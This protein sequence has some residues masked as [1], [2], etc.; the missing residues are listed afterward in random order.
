MKNKAD[1]FVIVGPTASGKTGL[2]IELA[3]RVA[4]EVISADSRQVYRGLDIGTEKVTEEEMQ[5]VPHHCIDIASPRR[6]FSVA[7]WKRHAE[8]ALKG[9][10][11]RGHV[12]IVAGGSG[13]F[14]DTL[15]YDLHFPKVAPNASLRRRLHH[16]DTTSLLEILRSLDPK[17][18]EHIEPE[19]PR[20]L[21]R[22]IE[23]ATALGSVPPLEYG[24][25][26]YDARWIGL[27]PGMDVLERRI[28]TRLD[29][30]L[31]RGLIEETARLSTELGLSRS[32]ID[33]L[34]LEYRLVAAHL[35]GELSEAEL[36]E[37]M[38]IE[39]RRY[40]KRQMTWFR[41]HEQIEWHKTAC[42]VLSSIGV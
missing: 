19:N 38:R 11:S 24:E 23:I 1:I 40:A 26:R 34:G 30:A 9:I 16:K 3:K 21:V 35:R 25:S 14:V 18:A 28:A 29:Q 2:S 4:G 5:G 10:V 37:K 33:E 32:R 42:D 22:A 6:A 8:R 7:Q 36:R 15:M 12:P 31:S 39:L 17:R 41:R 13:M 27:F 20:R